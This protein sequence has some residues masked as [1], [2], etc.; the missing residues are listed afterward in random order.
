MPN[1]REHNPTVK[2]LLAVRPR[3]QGGVV[4]VL[5]YGDIGESWYAETTDAKSFV[6]KISRIQADELL[7]RI[8]S[9]GGSVSDGIAIY[10]A[11]KQHPAAKKTV[12]VDGVAVSVA[13][14]IAMAGD[15]V[16]MFANTMLM[17]HAPWGFA[18]GNAPEL[19]EMADTLD[20]FASAMA[21][22]YAAK[23]GQSVDAI[24]PLLTDGADHWYTAEDA[25]ASGFCDEISEAQPEPVAPTLLPEDPEAPEPGE[26]DPE[27][28]IEERGSARGLQRFVARAP[29]RIAAALRARAEGKA[30]PAP[31]GG[32]TI[33]VVTTFTASELA[34]QLIGD[35]GTRVV[36]AAIRAQADALRKE[37]SPAASAAASPSQPGERTMPRETTAA[38]QP[39]DETRATVVAALRQRN[40]DIVAALKPY[41]AIDGIAEFQVQALADP[42]L[43]IDAVRARA[44]EIVGRHAAPAAG[45][46]G[47]VEFGKDAADKFRAGIE[48][49]LLIRAGLAANDTANPFRGYSMKEIA[50]ECLAQSGQNT[51]GMSSMEI[52]AAGFTGTSDFPNVLANVAEK[53]VLKG[54]AEAAE[55]FDQWTTVGELADFKPAKRVDLNVFPSLAQVPEG[56][57]YKYGYTGDRGETVQLATY[58]R[59]FA[60]TRQ[61][62][63]ND[64][65]G[66]FTRIPQKMGRAA[67]RTIGNLVYAIL[68][69]NP[70]MADGVALFHANHANLLTAAA[71]NSA[72][73]D[74]LRVAMAKQKDPENNASA[75]NIPIKYLIV[76]VALG[77][78]ARQVANSEYEVG[79]TNKNNTVPNTVRGLFNVVEDARLDVASATAWYGAADPSLFD[80][81]EVSYLDGQSTPYLEQKQGWDVDGTEFKV[82]I[83]AGVKAL[84]FRTLAKNPGA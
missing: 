51:R 15:T 70:N 20:V 33:K 80:T 48:S 65:L 5:I 9:Y 8:N 24:M 7:I 62:I 60:I 47:R 79:A 74:A 37:V 56:G 76:P 36:L 32:R 83:D 17:I 3:A 81:V 40:D 19:R 46:G 73:V 43:T 38:A 52:V 49:A 30:A 6:D 42:D 72:S 67:K 78:A 41:A 23:S 28:P 34:D 21:T 82:R 54:W 45:G 35:D 25:Q 57:E 77:G 71:I 39:A 4:E 59:M 66:V 1:A 31:E 29:S 50:R 14:L 61:A 22:S 69:G 18:C 44:L 64:D 55:T 53:A 2:P 58:G 27:D 16:R 75:L 63:I 13:S 84:D 11:I 12:Q 68:T 26:A 10:N